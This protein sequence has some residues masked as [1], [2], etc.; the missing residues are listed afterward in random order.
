MSSCSLTR[1]YNCPVSQRV[2]QPPR[3]YR[4]RLRPLLSHPEGRRGRAARQVLARPWC[5][6]RPYHLY[7]PCLK[8]A[9][10]RPEFPAIENKGQETLTETRYSD[11]AREFTLAQ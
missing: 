5:L 3:K 2:S 11:K 8:T 7:H 10:R 4:A 9:K 6:V 1:P